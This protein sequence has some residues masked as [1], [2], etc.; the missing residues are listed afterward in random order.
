MTSKVTKEDI[1]QNERNG[2]SFTEDFF[3]EGEHI[4]TVC[5]SREEKS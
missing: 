1:R 4:A 3:E 5:R 2:G